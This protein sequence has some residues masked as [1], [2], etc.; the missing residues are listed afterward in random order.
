MTELRV[1][2]VDLAAQYK[3]IQS[4]I[5]AA[6]AEI[7]NTTA[8]IGG[9]AVS[10]FEQA[11]ASYCETSHGVALSNGTDA[12][13]LAMKALGIGHGDEVITV[14]NTFIATS[15][16]ITRTGASIRFIDIDRDTM[17]M[18]V[19]QIERAITP[20]TKAIVPVHLYGQP[21][22]MDAI[23]H[24]AK[25]RGLFVIEDAAQA[26]GGRYRGKRVGSLGDIACFSFYPGKN[27]GAYGDAGAIVT[28]NRE[29]ADKIRQLSN[30]GRLTKYEHAVEGYNH[31]C[32]SLQ[33]AILQSKLKYLDQWNAA[34]RAHTAF[35]NKFFEG[36]A[37]VKTPVELA[38]VEPV[39]HLY[40][41]AVN[42]REYVQQALAQKGIETG[43]HYPLPLHLQPA[44]KPLGLHPGSFP[45]TEKAAARI[46]SLPMYAELTSAMVE[47]VAT[48]VIAAVKK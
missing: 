34:R 41:I 8:F 46:L 36:V 39:Y 14:P 22:D 7:L 6:I 21:A 18:N 11:F 33:A 38:G 24:L 23:N 31:R 45:A 44:Y 28:N 48:S 10:D 4:E 9:K 47:Y 42:N 1:P 35:Y 16:A 43:V 13:Y 15:E 32:D 2:F 17:N 40:V 30:H 27:L 3:T 25:Q 5:N 26:H 12:L 37:G 29:L 20:K 19:E